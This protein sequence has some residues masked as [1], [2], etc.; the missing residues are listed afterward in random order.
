M[1]AVDALVSLVLICALFFLG[2]A[3]ER[4]ARHVRERLRALRA[5]R[6]EVEDWIAE[7]NARTRRGQ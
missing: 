1:T 6:A 5:R 3:C 7:G 2:A 4:V